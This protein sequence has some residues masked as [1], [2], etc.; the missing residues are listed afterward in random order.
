MVKAVLSGTLTACWL[1]QSGVGKAH[2]CSEPAQRP[3]A[4]RAPSRGSPCGAA[5]RIPSRRQGPQPAPGLRK[6]A[7]ASHRA[8]AAELALI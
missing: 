4:R 3:P 2:A 1:G 7:K 5:S 6:G 8:L